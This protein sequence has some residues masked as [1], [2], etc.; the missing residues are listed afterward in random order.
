M[1]TKDIQDANLQLFYK[2]Y[3][4]RSGL[5]YMGHA[6]VLCVFGGKKILFDPVVLSKPYEDAWTFFPP[7]IQDSSV[8]KV[9][10]VIVSHIHQDHYDIEFLRSL[11]KSVK[12]IVIGGRSAFED[13]LR[14]NKIQN[15]QIIEPEKVVE[16][17]NGV[18][19]YGV[20]HEYNGIDASAVV[21]N[22]EFCIYH[23]ND[24]YLQ[25]ELLK[26]IQVAVPKIDV[27]C[28]PYAYIHWYPFLLE[29]PD[30]PASVKA[31]ECDRLV[32][33]HLEICLTTIRILQPKIMIP[34]GANILLDDGDAYSPMNLSGKTPYEFKDYAL[35]QDPELSQIIKPMLAGDFCGSGPIK[36][37]LHINWRTNSTDYR[38]QADKYLKARPAK[39]IPE[40]GKI[41]LKIFIENLNIKLRKISDKLNHNIRIQL[42]YLGIDLKIEISCLNFKAKW[43]DK[44][45]DNIQFH[46]FKLDPIASALWLNGKSFEEIISSRR[47]N[48]IRVPNQHNKEILRIV[49]TIL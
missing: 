29:F 1:Q 45:E 23:G 13:S 22:N 10:A 19:I 43:V 38:N 15:L 49:N 20:C 11:D 36:L 18:Y 6:S 44:F 46:L 12:V 2:E 21:Y 48:L 25:P 47:F 4:E 8:F 26:K 41:D 14:S 39:T 24:N 9:D 37:P 42:N 17:F 28:I 7:Q 40:W 27:A 34:F 32:N 5:F 30:E 16:I 3:G 31:S 33:M 35:K